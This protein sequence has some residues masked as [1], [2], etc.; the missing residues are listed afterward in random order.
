MDNT[1][2]TAM[3]VNWFLLGLVMLIPGLLKLF[4]MK[5]EA[6]VAMLANNGFPAATFF[7][8]VLIIGEIGSGVLILTKYEMKKIVYIPIIVLVIATFTVHWK[9]YTMMIVHLALASNFWLLGKT[10]K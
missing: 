5:P 4:V 3:K 6:I 2:E 7:A 8:W 10:F 9:N 1:K